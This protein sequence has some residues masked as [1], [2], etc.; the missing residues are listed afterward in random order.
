MREKNFSVKYFLLTLEI[1]TPQ[2]NSGEFRIWLNNRYQLLWNQ[3]SPREEGK[4]PHLKADPVWERGLG[5]QDARQFSHRWGALV[6]GVSLASPGTRASGHL[7]SDHPHI[8]TAFTVKYRVWQGDHL[9]CCRRELSASKFP[10]TTHQPDFGHWP[11][12]HWGLVWIHCPFT[13][14]LF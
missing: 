12:G 2:N 8:L 4:R 9:S 1:W 6:L 10:A 5:W 13:K 7:T 14:H 3:N 11:L